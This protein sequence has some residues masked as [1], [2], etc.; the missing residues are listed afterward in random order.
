MGDSSL[1]AAVDRRRAPR[2][3][4]GRR[5]DARAVGRTWPLT[6]VNLLHHPLALAGARRSMKSEL[7]QISRAG[8]WRQNGVGWR[9][10][11]WRQLAF[12]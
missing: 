1:T 6:T 12:K 3:G 5:R 4:V 2:R 11:Q 9:F 8:G 7:Q 10:K